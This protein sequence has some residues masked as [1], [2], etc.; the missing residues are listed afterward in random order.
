M[1]IVNAF[2]L[3]YLAAV[4]VGICVNIAE[5][6]HARWVRRELRD[7]RWEPRNGK[8]VWRRMLAASQVREEW[9]RLVIQLLLL[10]PAIVGAWLV[11]M[12]AVQVDREYWGVLLLSQLAQI[13]IAVHLSATALFN[14]HDRIA[15]L[16]SI[17]VSEEPKP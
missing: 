12:D 7:A 1:I 4:L 17:T 11:R 6:R 2:R 9:M 10:V 13:G 16:D 3:L 15:I 8:L 14:R 5:L